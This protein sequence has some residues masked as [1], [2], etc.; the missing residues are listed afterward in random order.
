[1]GQ[2]EALE[3]GL[4]VHRDHQG[5]VSGQKYADAKETA[6]NPCGTLGGATNPNIVQSR[7]ISSQSKYL[8]VTSISVRG[9]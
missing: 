6:T 4:L 2:V 7:R 5:V 8:T 3:G 9:R 1:M